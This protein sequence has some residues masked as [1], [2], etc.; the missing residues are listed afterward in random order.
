MPPTLPKPP[1]YG[2]RT[3]IPPQEHLPVTIN[4][5]IAREPRVQLPPIDP[6]KKSSTISTYVRSTENTPT[7]NRHNFGDQASTHMVQA[8]MDRA[9]RQLS[10]KVSH[11]V[12][13]ST[14]QKVPTPF[15][16]DI[17]KHTKKSDNEKLRK[18]IQLKLSKFKYAQNKRRQWNVNH[19]YD[20]NGQKMNLDKLLQ[21]DTT[22]DIWQ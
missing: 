9:Q 10:N 20:K 1:M 16:R 8:S 5:N 15:P 3:W 13:I 4:P 17:E 19:I 18:K 2:P 21:S 6:K 7:Y 14:N 22:K 11:Q 12:R